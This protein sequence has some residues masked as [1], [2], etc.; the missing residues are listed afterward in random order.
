MKRRALE[1]VGSGGAAVDLT[2]AE[3]VA[4]DPVR[5][6]IATGFEE[7]ARAFKTNFSQHGELGAAFAAYRDSEL[8]VDLWGG[9]ADQA[10]GRP[11]QQD[12]LQ[13]IFSGTKGLSAMCILLL[14]DRGQLDLEKA[15]AHYW[16]EFEKEAIT[17]AD[18]MSHTSRLP[19]FA[20]PVAL[21]ELTDD[22]HMAALLA[23]QAVSTDPRAAHCYHP[24][25]YGWLCGELVRRIDGRS[26]GRFFHEEIARPLQLELWIGLPESEERRV[27]RLELAAD[28]GSAPYLEPAVHA[29]DPLIQSIWGNPA[30]LDRSTFPW[31]SPAFHAAEMPGANA[32][33]TARSVARLYSAFIAGEIVSSELVRRARTSISDRWD[34][35]LA[36]PLNFGI[37]FELQTEFDPFGPASDGFGMGGAG[38]SIHGAWPRLRVSFSYAMNLMTDDQQPDPRPRSL[39]Q[40]LHTCMTGDR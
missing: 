39:L 13:L 5:G 37:G 17:V 28:W 34:V 21:E 18:V 25:T 4:G 15:V 36:G 14:C 23:S 29:D 32:I 33:G 3:S 20:T 10:S 30:F 2:P 22:R 1:D 40:A 38:G 11:W 31:N 8:I 24:L 12:T 16:P 6:G 35:S 19:G 7:V 26:I 9:I 27:S